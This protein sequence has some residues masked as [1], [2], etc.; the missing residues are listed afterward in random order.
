LLASLGVAKDRILVTGDDAVE[1]AYAR[2]PPRLGAGLGVNLRVA[3]YAGTTPEHLA[4]LRTGL[5]GVAQA[6]AA[7]LVPVPVSRNRADSDSESLRL[8]LQGQDRLVVGTFEPDSAEQLIDQV[9]L[10]RLVITG[11][12]HGAVFALS[13]GIPAVCLV[14]SPYYAHKFLG[15]QGLFP[16]GTGVLYLDEREFSERLLDM[17]KTLWA[18]AASLRSQLLAAAAEQVQASHRAYQHLFT[19]VGSDRG[20]A[21]GTAPPAGG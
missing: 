11:S 12:Y 8:L 1:L 7:P 18:S 16:A 5:L 17:A 20:A 9:G 4:A 10:C 21:E 14:R 3:A 15:L 19:V 6:C 2:R 13:Q